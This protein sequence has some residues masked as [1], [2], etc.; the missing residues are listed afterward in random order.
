[1]AVVISRQ[2]SRLP[3]HRP[4][5]LAA[6]IL[7]PEALF[8]LR[9]FRRGKPTGSVVPCSVM[10][11]ANPQERRESSRIDATFVLTLY[12]IWVYGLRLNTSERGLGRCP[13]I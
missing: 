12:Q 11:L 6:D 3:A 13:L 4:F 1:M 5:G 10:A 9:N 8:D 7:C 2:A